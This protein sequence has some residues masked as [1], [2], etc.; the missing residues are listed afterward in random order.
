MKNQSSIISILIINTLYPIIAIQL[1]D[2]E[3]G[4]VVLGYVLEALALLLISAFKMLLPVGWY[5]D[6][7]QLITQI[8]RQKKFTKAHLSTSFYLLAI[9]L[10][11]S[12]I[13]FIYLGAFTFGFVWL[14]GGYIRAYRL[15]LSGEGLGGWPGV[16]TF[17]MFLIAPIWEIWRIYRFSKQN[18]TSG[19]DLAVSGSVGEVILRFLFFMLWAGFVFILFIFLDNRVFKQFFAFYGLII[20]KI[21]YEIWLLSYKKEI[22]SRY[23]K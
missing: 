6:L 18:K 19:T 12:P 22:Y 21:A 23:I 8:T 4:D 15:P 20:A 13:I 1:W 14:M 17:L 2:W 9:V 5:G 10:L 3:S 16:F 11:Y 7:D